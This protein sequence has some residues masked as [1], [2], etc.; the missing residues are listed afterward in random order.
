MAVSL[1]STVNMIFGSQILDRS[2]EII[3]N[4]EVS[5]KWSFPK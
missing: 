3:L 2:T 1:T 5:V 4:D